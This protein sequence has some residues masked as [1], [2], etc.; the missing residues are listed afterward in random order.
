LNHCRRV[1]V[2]DLFGVMHA[3]RACRRFDPDA[4]V[5]DSD[6]EQMLQAA[7]HAPSAENTQPWAFVVVRL[8]R[9]IHVAQ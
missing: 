7:V 5:T 1:P 6:I 4:E 8:A 3:Q 9:R 2:G